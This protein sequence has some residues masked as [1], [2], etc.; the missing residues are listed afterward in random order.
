MAANVFISYRRDD[1]PGNAG[2]LFDNLRRNFKLFMDVD[3]IEPGQTFAEVLQE[4]VTQCD[5]LLAIIGA[6]WINALDAEGNRRLDSPQDYVRVEIE[7]ALYQKKRVIPVLVGGAEMPRRELLPESLQ[8]L[9]E[10][11]GIRVTHERFASDAKRLTRALKKILIEAGQEL[12]ARPNNQS[13]HAHI[14]EVLDALKHH[15]DTDIRE[16]GLARDAGAD[17]NSDQMRLTDY[18]KLRRLVEELDEHGV[19][20]DTPSGADLDKIGPDLTHVLEALEREL[21]SPAARRAEQFDRSAKP[22]RDRIARLVT[23][24]EEQLEDALSEQYG[25]LR[26]KQDPSS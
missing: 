8:P 26:S 11:Q 23:V 5:V 19:T 20:A 18:E 15:L 12:L 24:L 13:S 14:G 25:V 1:D 6:R 4:K 17:A 2:R 16:R 22:D 21:S 9:L 3:N 10:R 7:A